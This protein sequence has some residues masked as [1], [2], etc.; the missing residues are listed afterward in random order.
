MEKQET[1]WLVLALRVLSCPSIEVIKDEACDRSKGIMLLRCRSMQI[2]YHCKCLCV[3]DVCVRNHLRRSRLD[4]ATW[5]IVL[6]LRLL[7]AYKWQT[8]ILWNCKAS[9]LPNNACE[10]LQMFDEKD[11]FLSSFTDVCAWTSR[12]NIQICVSSP[13]K[14]KYS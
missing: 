7:F 3:R 5:G 9:P 11:H 10:L 8:A 4:T 2:H 1:A 13:W 12:R 14:I 6:L